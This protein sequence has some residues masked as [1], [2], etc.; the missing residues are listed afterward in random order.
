MAELLPGFELFVC[1]GYLRRMLQD[2]KK[3]PLGSRRRWE[4]V[5]VRIGCNDLAYVSVLSSSGHGNKTSG[6]IFF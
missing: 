5:D 2:I 3:R 4:V 6:L 1:N